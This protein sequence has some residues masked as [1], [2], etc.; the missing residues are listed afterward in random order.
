[1]LKDAE[2]YYLRSLKFSPKGVSPLKRL[3]VLAQRLGDDYLKTWSLE[4]LNSQKAHF[5][6][7]G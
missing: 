1:M 7:V 5:Q 3:Y 6:S 4:N 2:L